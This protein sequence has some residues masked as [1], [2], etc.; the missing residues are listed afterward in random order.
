MFLVDWF[1]HV[2][3]VGPD[4]EPGEFVITASEFPAR[5][6]RYLLIQERWWRRSHGDSGWVYGGTFFE[7]QDGKLSVVTYGH[8][9]EMYLHQVPGVEYAYVKQVQREQPGLEQI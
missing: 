1:V 9:S 3:I 4:F 7:V 5:P 6:E 8:C 2:L